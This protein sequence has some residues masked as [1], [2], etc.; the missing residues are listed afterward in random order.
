MSEIIAQGLQNRPNIH[1]Y[2]LILEPST[3]PY[4]C[5]APVDTQPIHTITP[6]HPPSTNP[7]PP[8]PQPKATQQANKQTFNRPHE[9]AQET[10]ILDEPTTSAPHHQPKSRGKKKKRV[11]TCPSATTGIP[12][13]DGRRRN[14]CKKSQVGDR[15]RKQTL[16]SGRLALWTTCKRPAMKTRPQA[17]HAPGCGGVGRGRKDLCC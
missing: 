17:P 9:T 3:H 12:N 4:C 14:G 5:P 11:Q 7:P 10:G 15:K 6:S 1:R 8:N 2:I 13:R 16:G